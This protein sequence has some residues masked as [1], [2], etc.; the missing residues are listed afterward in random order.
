MC[1]KIYLALVTS[2][3]EIS[4]RIGEIDA[5]NPQVTFDTNVTSFSQ[6]KDVDW[7]KVSSWRA[8]NCTTATRKPKDTTNDSSG[9][10]PAKS[11]YNNIESSYTGEFIV[12]SYTSHE[13][14]SYKVL[15]NNG[16]DHY[17]AYCTLSIGTDTLGYTGDNNYGMATRETPNSSWPV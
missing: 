11:N 2:T 14:K 16:F 5:S 13:A 1:P 15:K 7:E 6:S 3:G 4:V 9:V 10:I 12:M 17:M 8:T